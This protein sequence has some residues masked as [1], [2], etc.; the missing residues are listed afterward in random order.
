M[1]HT[2]PSQ[3]A[4]RTSS[5]SGQSGQCVEVADLGQR[6]GVR[7]SKNPAA[8]VLAVSR[9]GFAALADRIRAGDL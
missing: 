6:V 7:D 2:Q 4:W 1:P 9:E 3:P 5:H 8:G